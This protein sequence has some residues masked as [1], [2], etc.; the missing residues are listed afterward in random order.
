MANCEETYKNITGQDDYTFSTWS[1][2]P[3]G[4]GLDKPIKITGFAIRD[5]SK[6]VI[7]INKSGQKVETEIST[8]IK[9]VVKGGDESRTKTPKNVIIPQLEATMNKHFGRLEAKCKEKE[10]EGDGGGGGNGPNPSDGDL[11]TNVGPEKAPGGPAIQE[12]PRGGGGGGGGGGGNAGRPTMTD[13]GAEGTPDDPIGTKPRDTNDDDACKK[14]DPCFKKYKDAINNIVGHIK[15]VLDNKTIGVTGT[16]NPPPEPGCLKAI[17]TGK[18][19]TSR[20]EESGDTKRIDPLSAQ[21]N[22]KENLSGYDQVTTKKY[23]DENKKLLDRFKERVGGE[24][25]NSTGL[26]NLPKPKNI[27]HGTLK[28][29]EWFTGYVADKFDNSNGTP[30]YYNMDDASVPGRKQAEHKSLQNASQ[31]MTIIQNFC[32][33]KAMESALEKLMED[34]SDLGPFGNIATLYGQGNNYK[35]LGSKNKLELPYGFGCCTELKCPELKCGTGK[36]ATNSQAMNDLIRNLSEISDPSNP[37]CI[38]KLKNTIGNILFNDED[39]LHNRIVKYIFLK[40]AFW[41]GNLLRLTKKYNFF[42]EFKHYNSS[43]PAKIIKAINPGSNPDFVAPGGYD[44][45]KENPPD[46]GLDSPERLTGNADRHIADLEALFLGDCLFAQTYAEL[47]DGYGEV[48]QGGSGAYCEYPIIVF[49]DLTQKEFRV[50]GQ[51]LFEYYKNLVKILE[52][53]VKEIVYNEIS[54]DVGN[55]QPLD[56]D[57][58][59]CKKLKEL[60]EKYVKDIERLQNEIDKNNVERQRLTEELRKLELKRSTDT[61]EDFPDLPP[62]PSGSSPDCETLRNQYRIAKTRI[63]DLTREIG[64]L[65]TAINDS[66]SDVANKQTQQSILETIISK[67][68]SLVSAGSGGEPANAGLIAQATTAANELGESAG[69]TRGTKNTQLLTF[70]QGL[71]L[72]YIDRIRAI[73]DDTSVK[74]TQKTEKTTELETQKRTASDR[75]TS[76]RQFCGDAYKDWNPATPE[77]TAAGQSKRGAIED[78]INTITSNINDIDKKNTDLKFQIT[79]A[80]NMSEEFSKRIILL[81]PDETGANVSIR[82][83]LLDCI[84]RKLTGISSELLTVDLTPFIKNKCPEIEA[85]GPTTGDT[86]APG[87]ERSWKVFNQTLSSEAIVT[88]IKKIIEECISPPAPDPNAPQADPCEEFSKHKTKL[89]DRV[90]ELEKIADKEMWTI[91]YERAEPL[92]ADGFPRTGGAAVYKVDMGKQ[93]VNQ[94]ISTG[95]GFNINEIRSIVEKVLNED[96]ILEAGKPFTAEEIEF[97]L[98]KALAILNKIYRLR[99]EVVIAQR[100]LDTVT[101]LLKACENIQSNPNTKTCEDLIAEVKDEILAKLNPEIGSVWN[102]FY[103]KARELLTDQDGPL[104]QLRESITDQIAEQVK[105]MCP[106]PLDSGKGEYL[107]PG[108]EKVPSEYMSEITEDN[109]R[110]YCDEEGQPKLAVT[111]RLKR[112]KWWDTASGSKVSCYWNTITGWLNSTIMC[113]DKP[114]GERK[115]VF[116]DLWEKEIEPKGNEDQ[117]KTKLGPTHIPYFN[118]P[119]R[120]TTSGPYFFPPPNS[121]QKHDP[122][123]EEDFDAPCPETPCHIPNFSFD[124]ADRFSLIRRFYFEMKSVYDYLDNLQT[125]VAAVKPVLEVLKEGLSHCSDPKNKNKPYVPGPGNGTLLDPQLH[126][127]PHIQQGTT[128]KDANGFLPPLTNPQAAKDVTSKAITHAALNQ[129]CEGGCDEKD[130]DVVTGD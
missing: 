36:A 58:A 37:S 13:G 31:D 63:R 115:S 107:N 123:T 85:D 77:E 86:V 110:Y 72:K 96:P 111:V 29:C 117:K 35:N 98:Q 66:N 18:G 70:C 121:Y 17:I 129:K 6:N 32:C 76:I 40:N 92:Q 93:L 89:E 16:P 78:L 82:S 27:T 69:T 114:S 57:I 62:A 68:E 79:E 112:F 87:H 81:C 24:M 8:F 59:E 55:P 3:D 91:G 34:T 47:K 53:K 124:L 42:D 64:T 61:L 52:D 9:E 75:A 116:H 125:M 4:S 88:K 10:E 104:P 128:K 41:D 99:K 103:E 7:Y 101:K 38:D 33:Y 30:R 25:Y 28:W 105:K 122:Q 26:A 130:V 11:S 39:G 127:P 15:K 102:E 46:K 48:E 90:K 95:T 1:R 43:C 44:K 5:G 22:G 109:I 73:N 74:E 51:D 84:L 120:P 119:I 50:N 19:V 97:S 56:K 60:L 106:E 67:M 108:P 14:C 80:T 54:Q 20:S 83:C 12:P 118:K 45:A 94:R 100:E 2:L 71:R 126:K 65:N 21:P 113:D 23:K 49:I